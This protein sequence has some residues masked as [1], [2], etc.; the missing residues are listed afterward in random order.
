MKGFT[1]IEVAIVVLITVILAGISFKFTVFSGDTLYLKNFIYKL[2]S[3]INLI[4]DFSLGRR[5]VYINEIENKACGYGLSMTENDYLGYAFVTSSPLDCDFIASTTPQV[6]APSTPILY[7]QTNGEIRQSP[8]EPLQIKD[9]FLKRRTTDYFKISTA[10]QNCSDNLFS[11]YPQ[12]ALVYYNPY[13]DLLLLGKGES[14]W[15]NLL[16]SDWQN[17]YLCLDYKSEKRYLRINRSGQI[18]L[19][20]F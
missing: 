7:L 19:E 4:K 9:Q 18:I 16:P 8:I 17:I 3:N 15:I 14:S 5:I 13:G 11:S 20:N 12:I 10:S 2:S 1:L 6:F